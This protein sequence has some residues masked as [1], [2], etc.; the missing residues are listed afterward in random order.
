MLGVSEEPLRQTPL[1]GHHAKAGARLVAFAGWDM[2][3]QYVGIAEE[4]LAVR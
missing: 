4:H 3:V 1:H 2:P